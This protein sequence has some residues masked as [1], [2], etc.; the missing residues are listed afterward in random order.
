MVGTGLGGDG[1]GEIEV[2]DPSP[3]SYQPTLVELAESA[4]PKRRDE[5]EREGEVDE[6]SRL[7]SENETEW[8]D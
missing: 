4:V 6:G 5:G 1:R 2:E 3:P 8:E 7:G